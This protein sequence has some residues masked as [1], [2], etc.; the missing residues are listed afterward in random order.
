MLCRYALHHMTA[1]QQ[2]AAVAEMARVA[3]P[4]RGVVV[5]ADVA[6]ER[7]KAAA[8]YDQ[9]ERLRDASHAGVVAGGLRGL[10]GLA[11]GAGLRPGL[12]TVYGFAARAEDVLGASFPGGGGK[13][14]AW[15]ATL[16]AEGAAAALGIAL[17]VDG[18]GTHYEVPISVVVATRP[19]PLQ[20]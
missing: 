4:A 8:A 1:A 6:I 11:A 10:R 16:R 15:L 17:R 3:A 19:P 13:G 18:D 7:P 14:A 9:L 12:E 20:E 5:L 2:A